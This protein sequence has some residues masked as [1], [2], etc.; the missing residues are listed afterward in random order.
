M[1][2]LA[3]LLLSEPIQQV[4][5][6]S[7]LEAS[8]PLAQVDLKTVED[9]PYPSDAGGVPIG[10]G[11]LPL[12]STTPVRRVLRRIERAMAAPENGD[13]VGLAETCWNLAGAPFEDSGVPGRAVLA[14]LLMELV[15]AL[16]VEAGQL[17]EEGTARRGPRSRRRPESVTAGETS[18]RRALDSI[19]VTLFQLRSTATV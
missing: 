9:L 14:F 7:S 8:R 1:P 17:A 10:A 6:I 4:Y 13:L 11:D 2:I 16:E 18:L 15:A 5:R 12:R 3:A 19:A